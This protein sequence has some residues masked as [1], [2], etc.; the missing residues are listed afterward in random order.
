MRPACFVD[1]SGWYAFLNSRDPLHRRVAEILAAPDI[2]LATSS[3]VF[4]ELI[5]LVQA[6]IDH[7]TAVRIGDTLRGPSGV[8]I[9]RITEDLEAAAWDLF[10]KRRGRGYSFTDC[11]SF[12]LMRELDLRD[13]VALDAHFAQE[14]FRVLPEI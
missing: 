6:R 14:G 8:E 3:F 13:A 2:A 11:T 1:T 5:T 7:Q 4:D 10:R 9:L 12:V